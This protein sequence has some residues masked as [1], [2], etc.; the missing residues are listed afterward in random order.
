MKLKDP[1]EPDDV[2]KKAVQMLSRKAYT[3]AGLTERL[4]S[5]WARK[6]ASPV[7]RRVC[8]EVVRLLADRGFLDDRDFAHAWLAARRSRSWGQHRKRMELTRLGVPD[9][10]IE[11]M[12][13]EEAATGNE[14]EVAFSTLQRRIESDVLRGRKRTPVAY[15]AWLRGKGFTSRAIKH[16]F[17]RI[18]EEQGDLTILDEDVPES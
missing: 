15:A 8:E 13:K 2:R 1:I 14:E 9:E 10:I 4:V 12:L 17:S 5:W 18:E 3:E 11:S 16:A 7:N 6:S